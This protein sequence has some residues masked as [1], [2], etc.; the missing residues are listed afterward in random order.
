MSGMMPADSGFRAP[1]E[2]LVGI[3][4]DEDEDEDD[5]E[6][7]LQKLNRAAG[8]IGQAVN[9]G[10]STIVAFDFFAVLFFLGWLVVSIIYQFAVCKGLTPESGPVCDNP[11]YTQVLAI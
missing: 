6:S 1:R 11:I 7:G 9:R 3:V 4:N 5:D 10:I 2:P 8:G